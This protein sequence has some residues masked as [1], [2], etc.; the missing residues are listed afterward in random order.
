[1]NV[2]IPY[3]I[4]LEQLSRMAETNKY[5]TIQN[6]DLLI[7]N[8]QLQKEKQDLEKKLVLIKNSQP[9]IKESSYDSYEHLLFVIL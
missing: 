2:K 1:M 9:I 6:N 5:L 8:R 3:D 4:L 7:K